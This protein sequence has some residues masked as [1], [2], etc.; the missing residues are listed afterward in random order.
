MSLFINTTQVANITGLNKTRLFEL[1]DILQSE[2]LTRTDLI[3]IGY[4][5]YEAALDPM[6]TT[7]LKNILAM[8][9]A[10]KI[11]RMQEVQNVFLEHVERS[12]I[13]KRGG[14]HTRRTR[15]TRRRTTKRRKTLKA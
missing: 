5:L 2:E 11:R 12:L 15:R 3:P 14:S 8:L 9:E 10:G 7:N 6:H 4:E 1:Q 13:G